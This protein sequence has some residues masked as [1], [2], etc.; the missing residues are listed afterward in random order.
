MHSALSLHLCDAR[1]TLTAHAKWL[2]RAIEE[3]HARVAPR[4]SLGPVDVVVRAARD[5]IPQKG[6]VGHAPGP[7]VILVTLDPD[8]PALERNT[9][10][11]FERMLAHE[12]HHAARWD[13]PGYGSTLGAA[14]VTEGLAGHF[15]EELYGLPLELW[16]TAVA[17]ALLTHRETIRSLWDD[18]GYDHNEWFFGT[19]AYP[20]WLGYSA[21]Y[22][23]VARYFHEHPT[24]TASAL[25][26]APTEHFRSALM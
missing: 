12:M 21:A 2:T 19:G 6:H 14:L 11:S 25:A 8:N 17:D 4:L 22:Q 9:A 1:G 26:H 20:Q 7:G 16:E 18:A 13:G 5:V 23:L 15:V 24:A 10:Q 3:T